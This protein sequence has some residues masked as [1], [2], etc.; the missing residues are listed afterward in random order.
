MKRLAFFLLVLVALGR[1][2]HAQDVYINQLNAGAALSGAEQFPMFQNSNPP[3][4]T[5]PLAIG[6]YFS[7]LTVPLTNKTINCALNACVNVPLTSAALDGLFGTT[8]GNMIYRGSTGWTVLP[9]PTVA[10][11]YQL[12]SG[13]PGTQPAWALAGGGGSTFCVSCSTQASGI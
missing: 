12:V 6:N 1:A 11:S 3:V 8:Q 4:T 2:A 9:L 5:T 7:A 10:G 13:G